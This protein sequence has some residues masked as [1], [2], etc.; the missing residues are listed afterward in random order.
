[1]EKLNIFI[2]EDD[3]EDFYLMRS[4]LDKR[5]DV[6]YK[7]FTTG[8]ALLEN[9]PFLDLPDLILLD[10]K[11][12][13]LNGLEVLQHLKNSSYRYIPV[14]IMTSTEQESDIYNS[15]YNGAASYIQKPLTEEGLDL[16]VHYWLK[17]SRLP[18]KN[19]A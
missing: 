15:Y 10:L 12:P 11:M 9:L 6:S 4:I 18:N 14:I 13:V 17:L 2:A 8:V 3:H 1:M 7:R 16:I 5:L 19:A